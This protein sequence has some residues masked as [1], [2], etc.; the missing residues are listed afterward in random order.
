MIDMKH[1][2]IVTAARAGADKFNAKAANLPVWATHK[3]FMDVDESTG[4]AFT[5]EKRVMQPASNM[6]VYVDGKLADTVY[7]GVDGGRSVVS[8][9]MPKVAPKLVKKVALK[10]VK[11]AK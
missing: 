5:V 4:K 11:A 3:K 9:T 6:D 1:Q 2:A 7:V 10:F 8:V